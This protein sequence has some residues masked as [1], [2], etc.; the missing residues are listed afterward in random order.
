MLVE[1]DPWGRR[2][3]PVQAAGKPSE[4]KGFLKERGYWG[5]IFSTDWGGAL[6]AMVVTRGGKTLKT[7]NPA[8]ML[9]IV[10]GG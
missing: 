5:E 7:N 4:G 6:P 3:T 1:S 10:E 9:K 2:W 8:E